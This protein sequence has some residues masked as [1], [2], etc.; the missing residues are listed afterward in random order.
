MILELDA[1]PSRFLDLFVQLPPCG[2]GKDDP[3]L[4]IEQDTSSDNA[5]I[6][7]ESCSS[8]ESVVG[9]APDFESLPGGINM[10]P[11][12]C[13]CSMA[14]PRGLRPR[15]IKGVIL[16]RLGYGIPKRRVAA[17]S[18]EAYPGLRIGR[19]TGARGPPKISGMRI[20]PFQNRLP[21]RLTTLAA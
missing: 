5:S 15:K 18:M 20:I 6:A 13:R 2:V 17:R 7:R 1:G 19:L 16:A 8:V 21:A 11:N 14:G 12:P 9:A 3:V 10:A 4:G